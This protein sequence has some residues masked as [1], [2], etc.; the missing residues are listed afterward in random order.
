MKRRAVAGYLFGVVIHRDLEPVVS[1][2][3]RVG[4]EDQIVPN[5]AQGF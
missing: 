2:A 4:S 3:A 5:D 1:V